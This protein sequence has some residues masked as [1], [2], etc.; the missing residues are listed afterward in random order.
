MVSGVSILNVSILGKRF[1]LLRSNIGLHLLLGLGTKNSRLKNVW[2]CT[3]SI[4]FFVY[5]LMYCLLQV[6]V[7][8]GIDITAYDC[9]IPC[10]FGPDPKGKGVTLSQEL[11]HFRTGTQIQPSLPK[12]LKSGPYRQIWNNI[13]GTCYRFDTRQLSDTRNTFHIF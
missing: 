10:E 1:S 9:G 11:N 4:A 13:W 8:V 2:F 12:V 3:G 6:A 5:K 7:P